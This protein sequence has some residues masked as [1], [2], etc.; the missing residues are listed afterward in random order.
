M[1][2]KPPILW[3]EKP[4]DHDYNAALHFLSLHVNYAEAKRTVNMLQE[5]DADEYEAKDI[6]RA[7]D[8]RLLPPENSHVHKDLHK[9]RW[10]KELSPVL[11]VRDRPL[12]V[13]D[14][15]H[16]ICAAYHYDENAIVKCH[17]V[18]WG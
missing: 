6:L 3:L 5:A 16:R 10:H 4:E 15:Y 7:A 1:S 13:A 17:I 8:V 14:G 18:S 11:L 12:T 9:I 2:A